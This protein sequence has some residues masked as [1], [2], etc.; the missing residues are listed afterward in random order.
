MTWVQI[1]RTQLC[2]ELP[3]LPP[4]ASVL[5]WEVETWAPGSPWDREPGTH[6]T[7]RRLGHWQGDGFTCAVTHTYIRTRTQ[8]TI[9][10]IMMRNNLLRHAYCF[11]NKLWGLG[12]EWSL[13]S[14]AGL[15]LLALLSSASAYTRVDLPFPATRLSRISSR[16]QPSNVAIQ[17]KH[18]LF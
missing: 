16:L 13:S 6:S 11:Q 12:N 7:T 18:C 2:W 5:R 15:P 4:H 3:E 9:I 17:L 8:T 1:P 10:T 14:I